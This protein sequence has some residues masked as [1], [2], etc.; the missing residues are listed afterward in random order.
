MARGGVG[1]PISNKSDYRRN[2]L[3]RARRER[4]RRRTTAKKRDELPPPHGLSPRLGILSIAGQSRAS[5]Q[6]RPAHVRFGSKA[7]L[8]RHLDNV[9]FT[10]AE[11]PVAGAGTS[12]DSP[13]RK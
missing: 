6:K 2:R 10:L 11:A 13:L 3:L 7:D 5:Q 12:P 4:P 9:R 8:T 1:R